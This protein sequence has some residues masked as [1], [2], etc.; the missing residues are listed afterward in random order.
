VLGSAPVIGSL[1]AFLVRVLTLFG[2]CIV[3][4]R[5]VDGSSSFKRFLQKSKFG[6]Y[7]PF[8]DNSLRFSNSKF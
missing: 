5:T 3:P 1:T 8:I 4:V 2:T 6:Q 7:P